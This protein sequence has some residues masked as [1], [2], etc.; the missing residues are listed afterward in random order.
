MTTTTRASVASLLTVAVLVIA[1]LASIGMMQT[2]NAAA[3]EHI[4]ESAFTI[5]HFQHDKG[6]SLVLEENFSFLPHI[7]Q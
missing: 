3:T 1:S 4:Q 5:K 6:Y 2:N 7:L